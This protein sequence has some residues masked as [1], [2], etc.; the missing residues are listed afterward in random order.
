M[1][2]MRHKLKVKIGDKAKVVYNGQVRELEIVSIDPADNKTERNF[3]FSFFM[4]ELF[5]RNYLEKIR[6]ALPDGRIAE[7]RPFNPIL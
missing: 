6:V 5:G 7:C 2:T 1:N 3:C 4:E